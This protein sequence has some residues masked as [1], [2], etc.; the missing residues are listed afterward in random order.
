[1]LDQLLEVQVFV[2]GEEVAGGS[3]LDDLDAA[4]EALRVVPLGDDLLGRTPRAEDTAELNCTGGAT[5]NF[6][7]G[8]TAYWECG[9][10]AGGSCQYTCDGS[11]TCAGACSTSYETSCAYVLT[12]T[13]AENGCG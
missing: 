6:K 5:C 11:N 2:P 4:L 10:S 7:C 9:P 1:M 3:A 8:P 12:C 13:C